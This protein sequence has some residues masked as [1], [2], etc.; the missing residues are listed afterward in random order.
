MLLTVTPSYYCRGK[1]DENYRGI[2]YPSSVVGLSSS[3]LHVHW[4]VGR[5]VAID[6]ES[7][8]TCM[9]PQRY[10]ELDFKKAIMLTLAN[11]YPQS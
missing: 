4:W 5:Y 6:T 9:H 8:K 10:Q 7:M 1:A 3:L 2:S 11:C